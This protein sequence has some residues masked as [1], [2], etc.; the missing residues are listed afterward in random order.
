MRVL[1]VNPNRYR[2]PPVPPIG[3]EHVAA[4]MEEA[5]HAA[6]ILDLCFSDSPFKD[7]DAAVARF[8]P[9]I[10]G[11]SVRNVDS[12]LFQTNEFFLDDI[13]GMV[14]H[15]EQKHN[16]RVIIGG[17]GVAADPEGILEHLGADCAVA[18]PAEGAINELLEDIGHYGS[19]GRI[20][21]RRYR[22][23]LQCPRKTGEVEYERY[24]SQG[25]IGGFETHKGC[26]SSCVYCIEANTR[27]SFKKIDDVLA[28]IGMLAERGC[29]RFHLCDSEFNED[30]DY[31]GD[32]CNAL[33]SRGPAIEWA[34][35]M[36]PANYNKKLFRLMKESGVS[37]ITLTADSWKKCPLYWTDIEKIVFSARSCG[38]KI[39]VDFLC[40]FPY[41]DEDTLR[42]YLDLFRRIQPDSVG[43]NPYIRLYRKLQI[44][45]IIFR[46]E[47]LKKNLIGYREDSDLVRPVF[48]NQLSVERLGE[49]IAG[50]P[51]FRIEGLEKGVNYSRR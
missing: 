37:L 3:I 41:E 13:R 47:A 45:D 10:A 28:E 43:I 44:T 27:V 9:D 6:E 18:G 25:G 40:G 39:V 33:R 31:S 34:L 11:I 48:Y 36:K 26:S 22:Y 15:L 30:L 2:F 5:G 20:R 32:F 16:L 4:A 1:L 35:Y 38:L 19:A 12:V 17:A 42:F 49:L 8:R 7:I 24:L 14:R 21:Y 29:S 23:D 51:V 50:E 46:D